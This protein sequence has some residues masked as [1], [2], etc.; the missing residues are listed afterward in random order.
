[1]C[2]CVRVCVC[3]LQPVIQALWVEDVV[4]RKVHHLLAEGVVVQADRTALRP[5]QVLPVA[6]ESNGYGVRE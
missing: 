5:L 4:A 3:V 6:V 1:V 2:V